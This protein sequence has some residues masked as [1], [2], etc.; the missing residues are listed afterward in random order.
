MIYNTYNLYFWGIYIDLIAIKLL[1]R[2]IN[3]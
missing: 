2:E 1:D 3:F